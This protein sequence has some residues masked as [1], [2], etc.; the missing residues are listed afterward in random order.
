M[1]IGIPK[2]PFLRRGD[3]KKTWLD[4]YERLYRERAIFLCKELEGINTNQ[5]I[6]LLIYLNLESYDDIFLYINSPGGSALGG[7]MIYDTIQMIVAD[8]S[9]FAIGLAA[10]AASLILVGGTITK[11]IAFP[12]ARVLIHQP[13]TSY[14]SG[15]VEE[16]V[17]EAEEMF[18][19]RNE[20]ADMYA[21]STGK[22][23]SVI[24]KDLEIDTFMSA[25]Q[26]KVYCI[27]DHITRR[28]SNK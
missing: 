9:T 14:F 10:S 28:K 1:S 4:I 8:V 17:L 11:R 15:S 20:I 18:R 21:Q 27:V 25:T 23:V 3:K 2:V 22:P 16:I 12:H 13:S 7:M 5:I 19:I 6:A 24:Q 26:A